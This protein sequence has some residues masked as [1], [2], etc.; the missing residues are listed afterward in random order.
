MRRL[1][2]A[3][4]CTQLVIAPRTR[5]PGHQRAREAA[6]NLAR[7]PGEMQLYN[8]PEW[9]R[10]RAEVLA[11]AEGCAWCGSPGP[12]TADHVIPL[13]RAPE[14]GLEPSN[15]VAACRSCQLRRQYQPGGGR[16]GR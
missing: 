15:V 3:R 9:R 5:C 14:L 16:A 6:H 4:G 8:S 12:L 7:P 1:C 13:R 2:L 11:E 10:I